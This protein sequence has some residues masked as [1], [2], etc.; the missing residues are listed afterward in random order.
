[1]KKRNAGRVSFSQ[2]MHVRM[3]R[4][5]SRPVTLSEAKG[6][7]AGE[8]FFASLRTTERSFLNEGYTATQRSELT[9]TDS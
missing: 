5:D 1:M 2:E 6:L 7:C 3:A 9:V 8:R 4:Q